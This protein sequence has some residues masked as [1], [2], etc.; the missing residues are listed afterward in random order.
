V[1]LLE[2]Q[3]EYSDR[4][5]GEYMAMWGVLE[6]RELGLEDVLASTGAV[7]ARYSVPYDELLP[8]AGAEGGRPGYVD[9]A[10]GRRRCTLRIASQR[11]PGAR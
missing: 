9:L 6:A 2:R 3:R 4:V 5:R 8:P 10:P 1:V 11:L 7:T